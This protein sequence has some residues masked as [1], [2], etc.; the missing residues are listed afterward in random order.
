MTTEKFHVTGMTCAACQANVSRRVQKVPG[1]QEVDV[2]L[3]ANQMTVTYDS[4]AVSPGQ[5]CAAVSEI[6]YGAEPLSAP[7]AGPA[8]GGQIGRASCRERV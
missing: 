4:S 1:V 7:A 8:P 6:G 5:L 3:L 2:S